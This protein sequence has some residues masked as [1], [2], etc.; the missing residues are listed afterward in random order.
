[1]RTA[2]LGLLAG[3]GVALTLAA[4]AHARECITYEKG[5]R[6][7]GVLVKEGKVSKAYSV[8]LSAE[9]TKHFIEVNGIPEG[10]SPT[11]I[12]F[13]IFSGD[14]SV[15]SIYYDASG[16]AG[17]DVIHMRVATWMTFMGRAFGDAAPAILPIRYTVRA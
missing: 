6:N 2:I 8:Y 17:P 13:L 7:I 12:A 9:Q 10:Y 4:P 3:V 1:M 11:S 16:C 15:Y 14:T 5:M